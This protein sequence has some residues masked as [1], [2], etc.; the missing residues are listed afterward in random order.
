MLW[1]YHKFYKGSLRKKFHFSEII[2][3]RQVSLSCGGET[4]CRRSRVFGEFTGIFGTGLAC[5][6]LHS[7]TRFYSTIHPGICEL[8]PCTARLVMLTLNSLPLVVL[9]FLQNMLVANEPQG[10]REAKEAHELKVAYAVKEVARSMSNEMQSA[11]KKRDYAR[12]VELSESLSDFLSTKDN[13]A[14]LIIVSNVAESYAATRKESARTVMQFYR[15]EVNASRLAN[16]PITE[17]MEE[18]INKETDAQKLTNSDGQDSN[19]SSKP[20][21]SSSSRSQDS[22]PRK[23]SRSSSE[24]GKSDRASSKSKGAMPATRK[25]SNSSSRQ[26]GRQED[27]AVLTPEAIE[28]MEDRILAIQEDFIAKF[29]GATTDIQRAK[30]SAEHRDAAIEECVPKGALM[31]IDVEC[32]M[33]N[34]RTASSG[35]RITYRVLDQSLDINDVFTEAFLTRD[36]KS[37]AEASAGTRFRIKVPVAFID[38][39]ESFSDSFSSKWGISPNRGLRFDKEFVKFLDMPIKNSQDK[40]VRAGGIRHPVMQLRLSLIAIWACC[41]IESDEVP[42]LPNYDPSA[43]YGPKGFGVP[44]VLDRK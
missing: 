8:S 38:S 7:L 44:R 39:T 22:L 28:E 15:E 24:S 27:P 10:L 41:G 26:T 21:E 35:Y 1:L 43:I 20:R 42:D 23:P 13:P 25:P 19:D 2:T 30:V 17:E 33:V 3:E 18:F 9:I 31:F 16:D 37:L 40:T 34:S 14:S 32:E 4:C 5:I 6:S 36:Y 29:D 12:A 11:L